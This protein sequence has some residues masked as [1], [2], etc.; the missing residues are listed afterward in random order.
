MT[1]VTTKENIKT[2]VY[3]M[4]MVCNAKRAA[5]PAYVSVRAV[6]SSP[7]DKHEAF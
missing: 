5:L 7:L 3:S 1:H 4:S 2:N 6:W